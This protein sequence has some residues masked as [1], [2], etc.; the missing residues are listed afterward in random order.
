MSL[1]SQLSGFQ[2]PDV[3]MN[4]GPLPSTAGGPAGSDGSV[5]GVINGTSALLQNIS[6]YA[7]G[8]SA[9]TGSDRNYQQIPHRFQ[10]IIPKLYLPRFRGESH[11]PVSHAVD[12]GD[13]AF[14]LYGSSRAWWTSKD[15]F[16]TRAPPC[17]FATVEVVNY[18]LLCIQASRTKLWRDIRS[19]FF[20]DE[21]F[22]EVFER[23]LPPSLTDTNRNPIKKKEFDDFLIFKAVRMLVQEYFVPHGIC[24]G[25][26]HQGGQHE[27]GT[28]PVQAAVNFVITMTVDGKNVDLVNY[29]Y[30]QDMMAGDELVFSLQKQEMQNPRFQLT[31]YY[32]DPVVE[33]VDLDQKRLYWQLVPN[34]L[35]ATKDLPTEDN[36]WHHH[37]CQGYWRVAQ[38]FQN[39]RKNNVHAFIRGLPLE[40]T[41]APVWQ[42]FLQCREYGGDHYFTSNILCFD[43]T[44][45]LHS[46]AKR[47]KMKWY[48]EGKKAFQII[49]SGDRYVTETNP[50]T[51]AVYRDTNKSPEPRSGS[52]YTR[53][54]LGHLHVIFGENLETVPSN[55][56]PHKDFQKTGKIEI[57][58]NK[59]HTSKED[60]NTI[61][62]DVTQAVTKLLVGD[63]GFG[64]FNLTLT[65]HPGKTLGYTSGFASRYCEEFKEFLAY[66]CN[67]WFATMG[68]F[69]VPTPKI[70][71]TYE[72]IPQTSRTTA[73]SKV[74]L[75]PSSSG[76]VQQANYFPPLPSH[77]PKLS[78]VVLHMPAASVLES[79]LEPKKRRKATRI[80]DSAKDAPGPSKAFKLCEESTDAPGP[81]KAFKL[82]EDST[83]APGPTKRLKL[84]STDDSGR[85]SV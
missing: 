60:G 50:M 48:Y 32:K 52:T 80:F 22:K 81:S 9:R 59:Y 47:D 4:S 45:A 46:K 20:T 24:A 35:R 76:P 29:W 27:T 41:F 26:E 37:R 83:D 12:Q 3:L 36:A 54:E 31:R 63:A 38:T 7:M 78:N 6:P 75:Q 42:S 2:F 30:E 51:C 64:A 10:Y 71:V 66:D 23:L 34:I 53:Q 14:L 11:I 40:V 65:R 72:G 58:M 17:A 70:E 84:V 68:A 16:A 55:W 57:K 61:H 73:Q 33:T 39:R 8:K 74:P 19:E 43:D 28:A 21:K 62:L 44:K 1:F 49:E 85:T 25:S 82:C 13:I 77:Q 79:E 18:I 56:T 15:Q 5:D 69:V 67:F